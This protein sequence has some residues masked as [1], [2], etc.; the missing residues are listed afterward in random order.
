MK[1][2]RQRAQHPRSRSGQHLC[3]LCSLQV[4]RQ[5]LRRLLRYGAQ[6]GLVKESTDNTYSVTEMGAVLAHDH[7]SK[8][9]GV[10]EIW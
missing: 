3:L 4:D 1:P 6:F 7:P 8:I 9:C 2:Q 5:I 10:V